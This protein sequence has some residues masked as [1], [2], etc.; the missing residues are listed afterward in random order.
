MDPLM[1]IIDEL[2]RIKGD[3]E[4]IETELTDCEARID[5]TTQNARYVRLS[6]E[7]D[8][9]LKNLCDIRM[10]LCKRA[11]DMKGNA[12][13]AVSENGMSEKFPSIKAHNVY[14]LLL[15]LLSYLFSKR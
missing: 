9:M 8:L 5:F 4:K 15:L 10:E 12:I 11:T 3:C 13:Y 14:N 7:K 6:A 1:L 2:V